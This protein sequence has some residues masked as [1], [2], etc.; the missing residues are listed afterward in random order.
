MIDRLEKWKNFAN[1]AVILGSGINNVIDEIME[2]KDEI[3]YFEIEGLKVSTAPGHSGKF[4]FGYIEKIPIIAMQGRLHFYEGYEIQ[5]VVAPIKILSM[6][7]IKTLLVTNA[8]GGI[9]ENF[10]P[11]DLMVIKDHINFM[12]TNPLVGPKIE[13]FD[14]FPDMSYTYDISLRTLFFDIAKHHDLCV[15][16]GVYLSTTGPSYETP[17]E[18]RAFRIIGADAVGMSTVPEVIMARQLEMRV[19]GVSVISNMA[20]GI[21]EKKL[22]EEE[23]IETG[24]QV[25][26]VFKNLIAE[27][28]QRIGE[29][30]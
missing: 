24:R 4:L 10:V 5:D 26:S 11:G 22:S 6:L 1:I 29:K 2:I 30:I 12:G 3:S 21:L 8:A 16:E 20:A 7:G 19:F 13:G 18:I 23:V 14:R 28:I 9:N 25:Q 17:A 15:H 27:F